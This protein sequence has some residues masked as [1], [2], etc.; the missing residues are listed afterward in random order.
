MLA[1]SSVLQL[2]I[3]SYIPIAAES[4]TSSLSCMF[5]CTILPRQIRKWFL[6]KLHIF[7]CASIPFDYLQK[8]IIPSKKNHYVAL[9]KSHAQSSDQGYFKPILVNTARLYLAYS[10]PENIQR[11]L[12]GSTDATFVSSTV[13]GTSGNIATN[14]VNC[15]SKSP[16]VSPK[17]KAAGSTKSYGNTVFS[18][19]EACLKPSK[20][21]CILLSRKRKQ[22]TID[23]IVAKKMDPCL[24][25][26]ISTSQKVQV[27]N[28]PGPSFADIS[29]SVVSVCEPV[30]LNSSV[31]PRFS[32]D[33][34]LF[35]DKA[36]SL[37]DN[38]KFDLLSNHWKPEQTYEFPI[39]RSNRKF[40]YSW[41]SMFPWL[42]YSEVL[43]GAL[44]INCVLFGG[45]STHNA[46]KLLN[47]FRAPLNTWS[48][49]LQRLREHEDKSSVHRKATMR[50][51]Q[52][53]SFMQNKTTSVDLLMNTR[54][55][56]QIAKNRQY[57]RP[58]VDLITLCGKQNIPLRGHRDDSRYYED[59]CQPR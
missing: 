18:E 58:I 11:A 44:C 15:S 16:A 45:E 23:E 27:N 52:F 21:P 41:F 38:V 19:T 29:S 55:R 56:E 24:D 12:Q 33:I 6:E 20:L 57:L 4:G 14:N 50:V 37:A 28:N 39:D 59:D 9:C 30:S 47:L 42:V 53:K 13:E 22:L 49:A 17:L 7:R 43:S 2:P 40:Q 8:P 31:T 32:N 25:T 36:P 54:K 46:S 51:L 34:G 10:Q 3:E 5:N 1:L 48:S 26:C 35:I